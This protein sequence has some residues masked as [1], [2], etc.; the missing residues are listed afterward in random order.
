MMTNVIHDCQ[1]AGDFQNSNLIVRLK[2]HTQRSVLVNQILPTRSF[3]IFVREKRPYVEL[4][5]A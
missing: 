5:R 1:H 3:G 4:K 2:K